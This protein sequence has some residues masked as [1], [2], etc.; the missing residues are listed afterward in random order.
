MDFDFSCVGQSFC[1]DEDVVKP[2]Q[3]ILDILIETKETPLCPEKNEVCCLKK[4]VKGVSTN[5]EPCDS[6]VNYQCVEKSICDYG[7]MPDGI[8]NAQC[9]SKRQGA[10]PTSTVCCHKDLISDSTNPRQ[11]SEFSSDGY[12]LVLCLDVTRAEWVYKSFVTQ[13]RDAY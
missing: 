3:D 10:F 11:C 5:E 6:F 8:I 2:R 7:K 4:K 13:R 12:R 9:F 1:D